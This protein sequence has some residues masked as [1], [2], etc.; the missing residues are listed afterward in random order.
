MN[1]PKFIRKT[2]SIVIAETET[3]WVFV[4]ITTGRPTKIPE[5]VKNSFQV[6]PANEEP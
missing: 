4:N 3:E 6:V 2:D 5:S 1:F